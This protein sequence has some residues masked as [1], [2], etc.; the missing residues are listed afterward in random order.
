MELLWLSA[1]LCSGS[2]NFAIASSM[3]R[4]SPTSSSSSSC[5][6]VSHWLP[7]TPSTQCPSGTRYIIS[8][9][10]DL[11]LHEPMSLKATFLPLLQV[12]AYADYVFTSVFTAEIVLKVRQEFDEFQEAVLLYLD[13]VNG[14]VLLL[15][16]LQ[17]TTYGAFLHKGSFC[18]N[19]FNI[20]DLIVVGV[21]LL[22]MGME[23]DFKA[24]WPCANTKIDHFWSWT[25]MWIKQNNVFF[26][27][28]TNILLQSS[29]LFADQVPSRW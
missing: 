28:R 13:S 10:T 3:P 15:Y 20:L 24:I 1:F 23:W 17:M 8:R 5:S 29:R 6:A 14:L 12:L 4:P 9:L 26:K 7:R 19:S 11:Y 2:V 21:S 18:R 25:S 22:S 27:K 16:P